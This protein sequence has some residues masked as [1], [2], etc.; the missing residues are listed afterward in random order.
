[1]VILINGSMCY[2]SVR[3]MTNRASTLLTATKVYH[4][5]V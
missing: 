2:E 3:S 5:N 1:M 4:I